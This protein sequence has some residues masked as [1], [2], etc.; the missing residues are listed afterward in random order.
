[1][2]QFLGGP[3]PLSAVTIKAVD[4]EIPK[5]KLNTNNAGRVLIRGRCRVFLWAWNGWDGYGV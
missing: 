1:M 5:V 2:P 4:A 3:K